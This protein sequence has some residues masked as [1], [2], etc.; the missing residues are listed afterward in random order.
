[1]SLQ[2]VVFNVNKGWDSEKARQWLKQHKYK[3]LKRV[4]KVK[5]TLRYRIKEPKYKRYITRKTNKG[6]NLIFGY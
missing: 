4:H 2:S 5:N 1:M 6:V 3:P